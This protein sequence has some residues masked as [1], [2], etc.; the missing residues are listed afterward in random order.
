MDGYVLPAIG[1]GLIIVAL[2][3]VMIRGNRTKWYLV[4][5]ANNDVQ[6]LY[7]KTSDY[8]M[9]SQNRVVF[10]NEEGNVVVFPGTGHWVL[11]YEEVK[12][13]QAA[14]EYVAAINEKREKE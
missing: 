1:L 14:R 7:R 2:L 6:L 8:W 11:K 5:L 4:Y 13:I 12:D 10:H 3:V 9:G